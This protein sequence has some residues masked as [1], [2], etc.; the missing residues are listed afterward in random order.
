MPTH[1]NEVYLTEREVKI[2]EIY[3]HEKILNDDLI[4]RELEN[5]I[6]KLKK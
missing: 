4:V 6:E 5:L 2:L 1:G 3:V